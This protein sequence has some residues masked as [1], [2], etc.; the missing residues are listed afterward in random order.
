LGEALGVEADKPHCR[1]VG[2]HEADNGVVCLH[3]RAP[4]ELLL[5]GPWAAHVLASGQLDL[6]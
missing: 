5:T 3:G 1:H 2:E 4:Q 6:A